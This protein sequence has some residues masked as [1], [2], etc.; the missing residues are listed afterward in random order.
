MAVV[1]VIRMAAAVEQTPV[2]V[3]ILINRDEP[4]VSEG[5]RPIQ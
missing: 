1:S 3:K 4:L 5:G 2:N